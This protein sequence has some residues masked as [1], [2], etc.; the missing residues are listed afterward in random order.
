MSTDDEQI[1]EQVN[2]IV[3]SLHPAIEE[4][5]AECAHL[6]DAERRDIPESATELDRERLK[7][8]DLLAF[9][10]LGPLDGDPTIERI[11]HE[12]QDGEG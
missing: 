12:L 1:Q 6:I 3:G 9:L 5:R 7:D 11:E 10:G 2:E 4:L 8:P